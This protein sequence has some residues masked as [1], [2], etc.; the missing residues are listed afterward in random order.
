MPPKFRTGLGYDSHR[1]VTGR[2][3]V[4]GGVIIPFELGLEGH[5][6]AD[7]LLHALAD[8]L[9]GAAGLRDIGHYFPDSDDKY[10]DIASTKILAEVFKKVVKE[11]YRIGNVDAVIIA[12]RPKMEPHIPA[13]KAKIARILLLSEKSVSIKATSNEKMGFVGREEGLAALTTVLI[14]EDDG[15]DLS[16]DK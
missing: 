16:V 5:S 9:L 1:F 10:K 14:Y 7:A 11:G 6:D 2:P 3:L 13:M 15:T 12:E 8:A 4:L